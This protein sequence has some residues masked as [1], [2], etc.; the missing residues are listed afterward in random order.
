MAIA[1]GLQCSHC[2]SP[3]DI[4]DGF[5]GSCGA[6]LELPALPAGDTPESGDAPPPPATKRR[7]TLPSLSKK[8][9]IGGLA[10]VVLVATVVKVWPGGASALNGLG[11][12]PTR[13][14]AEKWSF[15]L[16]D[17]DV[18]DAASDGE[19]V[20]A[21]VVDDGDGTLI[22]TRVSDGKERW[23]TELAGDVSYA[24]VFA[25]GDV[26][27]AAGLDFSDDGG[28]KVEAF[29]RSGKAAWTY[30][31]SGSIVRV[32]PVGADSVLVVA[33]DGGSSTDTTVSLVR[34]GKE[35]WSVDG[36]SAAA[37]DDRVVVADGDRID[38]YKVGDGRKA[39]SVET[40]D[41][42]RGT[43]VGDAVIIADGKDVSAYRASNG[44]KLWSKNPGVDSVSSVEAVDGSHVLVNGEDGAAVLDQDGDITWDDNDTHIGNALIVDGDPVLVESDSD[45]IEVLDLLTQRKLGSRDLDSDQVFNS[46]SV[47]HPFAGNGL[48]VEDGS[49]VRGYSLP[50][51]TELWSFKTNGD[52]IEG[53]LALDKSVL[54]V[55]SDGTD[56]TLTLYR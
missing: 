52:D 24:S 32:Q 4:D 43:V 3:S 19:L 39:W 22:A 12:L 41:S 35:R 53:L 27:I 46:S 7:L 30:E 16:G 51:L 2:G 18:S 10:V 54:A 47:G 28:T 42:P 31:A 29:N 11:T 48:L 34:A 13:E 44:K 40:G 37:T 23:R 15:P 9:L 21:V 1:T 38:V 6:R 33:S 8:K 20:Y 25:L 45:Q 55:T 17:G 14:P 56:S 36:T 5:C 50:G 26:V 49:R